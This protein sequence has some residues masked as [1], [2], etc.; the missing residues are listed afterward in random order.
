MALI[1]TEEQNLLR[2]SAREF[3]TE[4]CGPGAFRALRDDNGVSGGFDTGVWEQIGELGWPGVLVPEDYDGLDFGHV[5]AGILFEEMG[6]ALAATPLLAS[7]VLSVEVLKRA[8]SDAQKQALLPQLAAGDTVISPAFDDGAHH[9]PLHTATTA[10]ADGDGWVLDG[11]KGFVI[12]G[13]AADH[14]LVSARTSGEAGDRKGLSLFLV[15]ADADGVSRQA[16]NMVDFRGS[17]TVSFDKVKLGA[18]ALVGDADAGAKALSGALDVG[19]C[20]IAAELL[21]ISGEVFRVTTTYLRE[22]KQFGV[23]IGSFQALQ[24]RAAHLM[25]EIETTRSL[26]LKTL[27]VAEAGE[28]TLPLFASLA[29]VKACR[30]ATLATNEAIQMHGGIGMTDEYDVGFYIK[31]ARVLQNTLG[32]EGFHTDRVAALKGY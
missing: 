18:D 19:N 24:H 13:Q 3:L 5:G 28:P 27:Q 26:V 30:T 31:R 14:F 15:A 7:A 2:D 10:V 16:H 17:A 22:R 12:D 25:S 9:R 4:T 1:Y 6:R 23:P 21:G 8:G 20:M 32:S 11:S 29:K